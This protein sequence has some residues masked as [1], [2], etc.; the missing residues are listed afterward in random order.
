[1]H[2][3]VH[4]CIFLYCWRCMFRYILIYVIA[5][6]NNKN[7]WSIW[8]MCIF[9]STGKI[10]L[11]FHHQY[12]SDCFPMALP[13]H[14]IVRLWIFANRM[15]SLQL[16]SVCCVWLFATWW[17][18]A[19]QA[20][21]SIT[22][23]RSWLKLMSIESVMPTNHLILCDPLLLLPPILPSIKV[24]SNES[25]LRMRYPKYWSFSL[26]ISPSN[27]HSALIYCDGLVGSPCS[28][29]DSQE[30]SPTTQFKNINSSVLS[31]LFGP[32]LTFIPFIHD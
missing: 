31:L 14:Y 15:V 11:N 10:F 12:M 24:F 7:I 30:S 8:Y 32:V 16:S 25:T 26:S 28:P 20:S 18:A 6:S 17:T 22:N 13:I 5:D 27:E 23:S 2:D 21:L 9:S 19:H 1:M 4:L 3:L 29:R